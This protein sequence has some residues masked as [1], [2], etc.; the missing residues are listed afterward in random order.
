MLDSRMTKLA[1]VLVGYSTALKAGDKV[2]IEAI[3]AYK[4]DNVRLFVRRE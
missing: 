2:L 1:E 3:E 4:P